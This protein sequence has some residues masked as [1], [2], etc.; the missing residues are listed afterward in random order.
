MKKNVNLQSPKV[1]IKNLLVPESAPV[2]H[3][4]SLPSMSYKNTR[5]PTYACLRIHPLLDPHAKGSP[6]SSQVRVKGIFASLKVKAMTNRIADNVRP[7]IHTYAAPI[8]D[9]SCPFGV[10][11]PIEVTIRVAAKVSKNTIIDD[12]KSDP[13]TPIGIELTANV[14]S[15]WGACHRTEILRGYLRTDRQEGQDTWLF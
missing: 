7:L 12:I 14:C 6:D 15:H 3:C 2:F 4:H 11:S 8:P 1:R 9:P 10:A 13:P 5:F